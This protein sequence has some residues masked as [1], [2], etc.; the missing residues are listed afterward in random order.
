MSD[1]QR[2]ASRVESWT[3][4][5]VRLC[6]CNH[7]GWLVV[8]RCGAQGWCTGVE[9]RDGSICGAQGFVGSLTVVLDHVAAYAPLVQLLVVILVN[10]S[11]SSF[12]KKNPN[13]IP[14]PTAFSDLRLI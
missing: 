1:C 3:N 7:V 5:G 11:L 12:G 14:F 8:C 6:M 10:L 4:R 2:V 13:K 9:H